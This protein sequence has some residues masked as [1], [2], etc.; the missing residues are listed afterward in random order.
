MILFVC[1]FVLI[2]HVPSTIFKLNR[3]GSSW[4]EPILSY[5]KCVLFKDHNA[6]TRVRLE[7][8]ASQSRV[9]HS[10]SE[11]LRSHNDFVFTMFSGN[12]ESGEP[13]QTRI[14]TRAFASRIHKVYEPRHEISNNV[15]CATSKACA[16]LSI[17]EMVGPDALGVVRATEVYLLDFVFAPVFSFF[18]S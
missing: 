3:D 7:L 11:P 10:T 4:V 6:V 18:Y 1:L 14:L 15:V 5:D 8:A 2:I 9:K 12:E 17:D 16:D 13:V